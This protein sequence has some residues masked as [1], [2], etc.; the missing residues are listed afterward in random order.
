MRSNST[1]AMKADGRRSELAKSAAIRLSLVGIRNPCPLSG[2]GPE[3]IR[4]E[5]WPTAIPARQS[6]KNRRLRK[7][8]FI[9]HELDLPLYLMLYLENSNNS[10]SGLPRSTCTDS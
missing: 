2:E 6:Q 8:R 10:K 3:A 5:F 1:G 4:T 9:N 7:L